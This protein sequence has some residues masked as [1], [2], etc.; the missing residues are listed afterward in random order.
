MARAWWAAA[1]LCAMGSLAAGARGADVNVAFLLI[2]SYANGVTHADNC[3]N[4]SGDFLVENGV[5]RCVWRG[6]WQEIAAGAL[7]GVVDFN[8][9]DGRYVEELSKL[10]ACDKQLVPRVIDDGISPSLAVSGLLDALGSAHRPDV[11]IGASASSCSVPT[12]LITGVLNIPQISFWSTSSQLDD[13]SQFPRF[14]RTI[15]PDP[16]VAYAVCKYWRSVGYEHA[17]VIYV[18]DNYGEA[19]K[20]AIVSHCL[21]MGFKSVPTVPFGGSDGPAALRAQVAKL[22]AT[23]LNV[24]LIVAVSAS[25]PTILEEAERMG[26]LGK[27]KSWMLSDGITEDTL[28]ALPAATQAQASGMLKVVAAGGTDS[29][30]RFQAYLHDW[31]AYNFSGLDRFVQ[32]W[33]RFGALG[34]SAPTDMTRHVGT[35]A[36]D[37]VVAAGLLACA[38]APQGAL[39][40]DWGAQAWAAKSGLTFDGLSGHVAFDERGNRKITTVNFQMY[41]VRLAGGKANTTLAGAFDVAKG[42][43]DLPTSL[44]LCGDST[45]AI[46]DRP[47]PEH[48]PRRPGPALRSAARAMCGLNVVLAL[49]CMAWAFLHRKSAVVRASQFI[50]LIL[51]AVGTMVSSLAILPLSSDDEEAPHELFD[52]SAD[53]ALDGGYV[54]ANRACQNAIRLYNTGFALV[55]MSLSCKVYKVKVLFSQRGMKKVYVSVPVLLGTIL[56]SILLMTVLDELWFQQAPY[57]FQRSVRT[58]DPYGSPLTSTGACVSEGSTTWLT[59]FAALQF[60]MQFAGCVLCYQCRNV[61]TAFSEG[62]YVSVAMISY[63]QV[64]ALAVPVL[65]IVK[66]NPPARLLLLAGVI[67]ANNLT[68][69]LLIYVPKMVAYVDNP[70]QTVSGLVETSGRSSSEARTGAATLMPSDRYKAGSHDAASALTEMRL[71]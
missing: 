36:Y 35:Y 12:A 10:G 19:Y 65:I 6:I 34:A 61:S 71:Q 52:Y 33:W 57:S 63:L 64:M 38:V 50:F 58:R 51:I 45:E 11:V 53:L 27:G 66:D 37:A 4:L 55:Y 9:R 17:G 46:S 41:S 62:K 5:A 69:L 31:G 42:R 2:Q 13:K 40:A 3:T 15:A 1:A 26:M 24:F 60:G 7:R 8:A 49:A 16:F 23:D 18:N 30:S 67:F 14:M 56:S 44:V 39:P 25:V 28:L 29:N 68:V 47:R 22:R 54:P 20:E 32:P 48:D 21:A 70:G 43:W 59:A